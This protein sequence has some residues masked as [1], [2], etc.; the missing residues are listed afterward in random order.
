MAKDNNKSKEDVLKKSNFF[1]GSNGIQKESKDDRKNADP[2][3]KTVQSGTYKE[4]VSF[5]AGNPNV[6]EAAIETIIEKYPLDSQENWE[7]R[8]LLASN[9]NLPLTD[10]IRRE[11]ENAYKGEEKDFDEVRKEALSRYS[12]VKLDAHDKL[13]ENITA[14]TH[15]TE[16]EFLLAD[17][18]TSKETKQQ[19]RTRIKEENDKVSKEKKQKRLEKEENERVE[20][21]IVS[22]HKKDRKQ[23][24][25]EAKQGK[26]DE[27]MITS[28]IRGITGGYTQIRGKQQNE[29]D[30]DWEQQKKDEQKILA[31][32]EANDI[33]LA[34][35]GEFSE[36][37]VNLARELVGSTWKKNVDVGYGIVMPDVLQ[38]GALNTKDKDL[39]SDQLRTKQHS[40]KLIQLKRQ[41]EIKRARQGDFS[42]IDLEG[43]SD[44]VVK[45]DEEHRKRLNQ[46][47]KQNDIKRA[48]QGDFSGVNIPEDTSK[49]SKEE[50]RHYQ[51]LSRLKKQAE[52]KNKRQQEKSKKQKEREEKENKKKEEDLK[53]DREQNPEKY[54]RSTD[55]KKHKTTSMDIGDV[56]GSGL[57]SARQELQDLNKNKQGVNKASEALFSTLKG[58]TK[59]LQK[60]RSGNA[61][62]SA[63]GLQYMKD[64]KSQMKKATSKVGDAGD[65]PE[66]ASAEGVQSSGMQS[67]KVTRQQPN[68]HK[69]NI[70]ED[71][72]SDINKESKQ[73]PD[74]KT[75]FA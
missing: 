66:L 40:Q 69:L 5:I 33:K 71:R 57:Q 32:K 14:T 7:L 26:F 1:S 27:K 41:D 22:E 73:I 63:Q 51:E 68:T 37:D 35:K 75:E 24:L 4:V 67:A 9:K 3:V 55:P 16:A 53:T 12:D 50:Q 11:M 10:N 54:V 30:K 61:D 46:L 65:E 52:Q 44:T 29:F 60:L 70:V 45:G 6:S 62:M 74:Y 49:L 42:N 31:L 15:K 19:I 13:G 21:E 8:D 58:A 17:P 56:I 47:K 64:M 18:N 25:N 28:A 20:K 38:A 2:F 72:I 48:R 36:E 23:K 43:T 39:N 59:D 34:K